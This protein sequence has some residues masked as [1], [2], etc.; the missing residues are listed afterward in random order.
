MYNTT[1]YTAESDGSVSNA[2]S[3]GLGE[4]AYTDYTFNAQTGTF[5]LTD[6]TGFTSLLP[7]MTWYSTDIN[8]KTGSTTSTDKIYYFKLTSLDSSGDYVANRQ[9]IVRNSS[10]G[11]CVA[12]SRNGEIEITLQYGAKNTRNI[13]VPP[14]GR[15]VYTKYTAIGTNAFTLSN[16][17]YLALLNDGDVY[18]S[19]ESD[20]SSDGTVSQ[21]IYENYIVLAGLQET[22][23]SMYFAPL[24]NYKQLI[25]KV[26]APL[27]AFKAWA[28]IT[29]QSTYTQQVQDESGNVY[30][31]TYYK[32]GNLLFGANSSTIPASIYM[33]AIH[34]PFERFEVVEEYGG[35]GTSISGYKYARY[36]EGT[37]YFECDEPVTDVEVGDIIFA[38]T[39]YNGSANGKA[40]LQTT[41]RGKTSTSYTT[42]T[43]TIIRKS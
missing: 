20:G 43:E 26:N 10:I 38:P 41:I 28:F 18:Y 17:T 39:S 24:T 13:A 40:L 7:G 1:I 2:E 8:G 30:T 36:D 32:G 3:N 42:K 25:L 14:L 37:G 11:S 12:I 9:T 19:T 21:V 16:P 23:R 15:T 6:P 27:P 29:P 5:Y 33:T 35:S 22:Y 34:D 31:E 4:I